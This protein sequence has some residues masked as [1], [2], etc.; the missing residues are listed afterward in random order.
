MSTNK[1]EIQS[2]L[3]DFSMPSAKN[4]EKKEF[5]SKKQIENLQEK[6]KNETND[7]VRKEIAKKII[8]IKINGNKK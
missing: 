6:L 1:S 4:N 2:N 8:D 3:S 5:S 7:V